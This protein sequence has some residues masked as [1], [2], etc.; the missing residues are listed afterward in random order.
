MLASLSAQVTKLLYWKTEHDEQT[1]EDALA[2][3]ASAGLFAVA[4]GVGTALFSHIWAR[5]LV[6]HFVDI[7]LLSDDP[8]EVEWW[9]RKAQE[10]YQQQLPTLENLP[11]NALQKIQNQG[12]YSTLAAACITH[13]DATS[14]RAS[15]LAFGDSC[16][17][18][19]KVKNEQICAFPL[20]KPADFDPAP[21]CLPSKLSNFQRQFQRCQL[22][23]VDLEPGDTLLLATD[24]VARWILSAGH[25]RYADV[26]EA[27]QQVMTQTP[28]SWPA[29][30]KACRAR[31]EMVDDDC[32]VLSIT[33]TEDAEHGEA[34]GGTSQHREEV[35]KQR[36]SAFFQALA[37]QNKEQV[38]ILFGDGVDL[39]QEAVTFSD[40]E[41]REA[42]QVAD[43]LHELLQELRREINSSAVAVKM[44]P[45]WQKYALLLH[46]E[47][48]AAPLRRTLSRLGVSLAP[49]YPPAPPSSDST[50]LQTPEQEPA[51]N[52]QIAARQMQKDAHFVEQAKQE[53]QEEQEQREAQPLIPQQETSE[54]ATLEEKPQ[55]NG[56]APVISQEAIE[57]PSV[58]EKAVTGTITEAVA[59]IQ[60]PARQEIVLEASKVANQPLSLENAAIPESSVPQEELIEREVPVKQQE[61]E[62]E[63]ATEDLAE[64]QEE[65][66]GEV[67]AELAE[68][69]EDVFGE[70]LVGPEASVSE[71][72]LIERQE[73]PQI[74]EVAE[75]YGAEKKAE[76]RREVVRGVQPVQDDRQARRA[77]PMYYYPSWRLFPDYQTPFT[78]STLLPLDAVESEIALEGEWH[79]Q[80]QLVEQCLTRRNAMFER[81]REQLELERHLLAAIDTDDDVQI[82]AIHDA[83]RQSPAGRSLDLLLPTRQRIAQA[84]RHE[85][86]RQQLQQYAEQITDVVQGI[87][88]RATTLAH[89][90]PSID[91]AWFKKVYGVKQAYLAHWL[92]TQMG[93][94]HL[95][96]MTL[97]D[98]INDPLIEA[99]LDEMK[100]DQASSRLA[101][102][103]LLAGAFKAFRDD[104]H[105]EYAELLKKY[106]LQEEDVKKILL[107]FLR[108]QLFE[109]QLLWNSIAQAEEQEKNEAKKIF[110]QRLM[111]VY[112]WIST[113][114]WW[115][116]R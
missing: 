113:L 13:V 84:R 22:K 76:E 54:T 3:N 103:A 88:D 42:R 18:V 37:E 66:I 58:P 106:D 53:E 68:S 48:C 108:H 21:V 69:Q 17:L 23:Q 67:E 72:K 114:R 45:L 102:Q 27:F 94:E 24:V 30:I 60:E 87:P 96:R 70:D 59:R 25:G 7:P 86:E 56:G 9:L 105:V 74:D 32:A 64:Q 35:R 97:D 43:A 57:K 83:L 77:L 110:R 20:D 104:P 36:K 107:I 14:A 65:V 16:V 26:Q 71:E 111:T 28:A 85:V 93:P 38:A 52:E 10:C 12:S 89:G 79:A 39:R 49:Q 98:L 19:K 4:D 55:E 47:H 78:A 73:E 90:L 116:E 33:L 50:Q 92:F 6:D 15:L 62:F 81:Q 1:C 63:E 82:V 109:E 91:E 46:D 31:G 101:P 99:G 80:Q 5:L 112:P 2:A 51:K 44:S 95:E 41:V 100:L 8:F 29:F 115:E 40:E 34:L 11:W 75:A 61:E